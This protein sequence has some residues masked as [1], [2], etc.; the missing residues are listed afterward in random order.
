MVLAGEFDTSYESPLN[1]LVDVDAR[2]L[3]NGDGQR[4][5]GGQP[6]EFQASTDVFVYCDVPIEL[7]E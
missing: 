2:P 7:Q 5:F 6:E 4:D 3:C 1:H